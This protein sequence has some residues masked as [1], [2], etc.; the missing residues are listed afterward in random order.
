MLSALTVQ[1]GD[2]SEDADGPRVLIV[3]DDPFT[4][5]VLRGVVDVPPFTVVG[6]SGTFAGGLS[7]ARRE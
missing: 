2:M 6:V 7:A 5:T 1:D 4:R 3:D